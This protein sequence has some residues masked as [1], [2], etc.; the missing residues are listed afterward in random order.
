M[1][2]ILALIFLF[3]IRFH[4]FGQGY[5]STDTSIQ[6]GSKEL[7]W[8]D[9]KGI[10]PSEQ[11][12]G[13]EAAVTASSVY[14]KYTFTDDTLRFFIHSFFIKKQSWTITDLEY[15]LSHERK[16]FDIAE[17][18]GRKMRQY[19]MGLEGSFVK[20]DILKSRLAEFSNERIQLQKTYD[21][22]TNH[23]IDKKKQKIWD[24]KIKKMLDSLDAYKQPYGKIILKW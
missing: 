16:H 6:W 1:T 9:F 3:L 19:F 15:S 8:C 22:E 2:K 5:S 11:E 20:K 21:R 24:V 7:M 17:I 13:N 14:C 4:C 10:P 18:I 12:R 23:G